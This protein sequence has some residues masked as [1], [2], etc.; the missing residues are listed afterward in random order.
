M[1]LLV[2]ILILIPSLV[3]S[4]CIPGKIYTNAES[5]LHVRELTGKN[6]GPEVETWLKYVGLRRGDPYCAAMIVYASH[7]ATSELKIKDILPKT[8]RSATLLSYAKRKPLE[9]KVISPNQVI[10]GAVK[11]KL[12]DIAIFQRGKAVGEDFSGHTE[13]VKAPIDKANFESIGG[14]TGASYAGDQ[15]EGEGVYRKKRKINSVSFPVRGFFRVN[16]K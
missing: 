7:L 9:F 8:G 10:L 4:E 12:G 5:F 3:F 2:I 6:D 11:L 14:N 16:E 15:G 1:K 13:V